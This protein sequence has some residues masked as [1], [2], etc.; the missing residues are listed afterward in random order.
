MPWQEDHNSK[1]ASRHYSPAR[2]ADSQTRMSTPVDGI[3][4]EIVLKI[5]VIVTNIF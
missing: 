2:E 4:L 3:E 1:E 5:K